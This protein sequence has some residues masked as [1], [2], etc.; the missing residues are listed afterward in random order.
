MDLT[1][2][3]AVEIGALWAGLTFADGR[4]LLLPLFNRTP[5]QVV[6]QR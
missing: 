1:A 6:G 3:I 5:W 2:V 4:G